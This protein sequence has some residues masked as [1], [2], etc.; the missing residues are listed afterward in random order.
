MERIRN[1][2]ALAWQALRRWVKEAE[3]DYQAR[4]AYDRAHCTICGRGSENGV[5]ICGTC[6]RCDDS[7]CNAGC[8]FCREVS[9][10][11]ATC[12]CCH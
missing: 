8:I 5:G 3:A 4:V 2:I 9:A 11:P 10:R 1:A 6:N 12:P 7:G